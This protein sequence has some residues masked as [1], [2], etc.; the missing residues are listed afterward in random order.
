MISASGVRVGGGQTGTLSMPATA[1]SPIDT[2]SQGAP[3][4]SDPDDGR[5]ATFHFSVPRSNGEDIL[6]YVI[7]RSPAPSAPPSPPHFY[8]ISCASET[9]RARTSYTPVSWDLLTCTTNQMMVFTVG[10]DLPPEDPAYIKPA[11][12]HEWAVI[13]TRASA[14]TQARTHTEQTRNK[15]PT[16]SLPLPCVLAAINDNNEG[17]WLTE[18][19]GPHGTPGDNYGSW[20]PV[21]PLAQ[22][23]ASPTE[24]AR[25]A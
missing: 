2:W 10:L 9:T 13:G 20:S 5:H 8:N 24:R 14:C 3:G 6:Y 12:S 4:S 16:R 22:A 21:L 15:I 17:C 23:S 25:I 18:T 1:P 7:R 11:E 19:C